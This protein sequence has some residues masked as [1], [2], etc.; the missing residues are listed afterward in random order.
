MR[1]PVI[2][3]VS[4][5]SAPRTIESVTELDSR[6]DSHI[7]LAIKEVLYDYVSVLGSYSGVKNFGFES[8][9]KKKS[10]TKVEYIAKFG[11]SQIKGTLNKRIP[12]KKIVRDAWTVADCLLSDGY[13]RL[14]YV[15]HVDAAHVPGP[16]TYTPAR[17]LEATFPHFQ[18]YE[19]CLNP[20]QSMGVARAR[21]GA[22]PGAQ[23]IYSDVSAFSKVTGHR[24]VVLLDWSPG[25]EALVQTALTSNP[26]LQ[27]I[28]VKK[29]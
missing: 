18:A 13:P 11:S 19:L 22:Y 3:Q 26:T 12:A 14:T 24:G 2:Q 25:D 15:A 1:E 10:I 27:F 9:L 20:H 28:L 7:V 5:N 16:R 17:G 21:T 8:T 29:V 6:R 4:Y 23:L